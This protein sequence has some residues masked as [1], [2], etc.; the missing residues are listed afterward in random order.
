M[1]DRLATI[2]T[3]Q[4]LARGDGHERPRARHARQPGYFLTFIVAGLV[5][6]TIP[7]LLYELFG[8]M[9][10]AA[11][12]GKVLAI[13]T[14]GAAVIAVLSLIA[15]RSLFDFQAKVRRK[16]EE[17]LLERIDDADRLHARARG[18]LHSVGSG[19]L[20]GTWTSPSAP[21]SPAPASRH[22]ANL[23]EKGRIVAGPVR[24][25][26]Y[27]G[28]RSGGAALPAIRLHHRCLS[29]SL[30]R[31]RTARL[32]QNAAPAHSGCAAPPAP[33]RLAAGGPH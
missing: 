27:L 9:R 22:R 8:G 3:K 33:P 12:V 26:N 11:E 4:G 28:R 18:E 21:R 16:V 13:V 7:I 6:L 31:A 17:L 20:S 5:A 10:A 14:V 23:V 19:T 1:P 32:P 24:G 15:R 29:P 25:R 30:R 2:R